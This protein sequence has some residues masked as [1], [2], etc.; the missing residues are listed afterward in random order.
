VGGGLALLAVVSAA[1]LFTLVGCGGGGGSDNKYRR[2][3]NF[4][5]QYGID[6]AYELTKEDNRVSI[7]SDTVKDV[8]ELIY[9]SS[10]GEPLST[11]SETSLTASKLIRLSYLPKLKDAL[12]TTN[13]FRVLSAPLKNGDI[14]NCDISGY[15]K[16]L[17]II[18]A[19]ADLPTRICSD[20]VGMY[21]NGLDKFQGDKLFFD[22]LLCDDEDL[23]DIRLSGFEQGDAFLSVFPLYASSRGSYEHTDID[24]EQ[25]YSWNNATAT[26]I[27]YFK[28]GDIYSSGVVNYYEYED[29]D[30]QI[31]I[32][33]GLVGN[34]RVAYYTSKNVGGYDCDYE[35][36]IET[37]TGEHNI[38]RSETS[39]QKINIVFGSG[40]VKVDYIDGDNKTTK[41]SGTCAEFANWL[42]N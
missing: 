39:L 20:D 38:S 28:T 17:A 36:G 14:I 10:Y 34:H 23:Y 7:S 31:F 35:D 16:F 25:I 40:A 21:L 32:H 15:A 41:F 24:E 42:N 27:I 19:R 18:P 22:N 3:I 33:R 4:D 8:I 37:Q 26:S 13:S 12:A 29:F 30:N 6:L 9:G 11:L 1:T 5:P 2:D